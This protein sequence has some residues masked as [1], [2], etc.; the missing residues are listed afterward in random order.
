[1]ADN[2]TKS[3]MADEIMLSVFV[4]VEGAHAFSAFM[5]STFTT[6]KFGG[7]A[8][9]ARKLRMGFIPAI[10]FNLILGGTVSYFA[11]SKK[12]LVAAL[13]VT[14]GMVGFYEWNIHMG[15]VEGFKA[16]PEMSGST[17]SDSFQGQMVRSEAGEGPGGVIFNFSDK[18]DAASNQMFIGGEQ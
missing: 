7:A 8:E 17:P 18:G 14:G 2:V 10:L 11:G 13:I 9:D 4:A 12:P 5:P 16:S 15:T 3:V 1:M 6:L